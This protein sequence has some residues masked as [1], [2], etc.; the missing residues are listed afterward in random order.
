MPHFDSLDDCPPGLRKLI[1]AKLKEESGRQIA[2]PTRSGSSR[3]P[4]PTAERISA[5]EAEAKRPKYGNKPTERIAPGGGVIKFDSKKEAARYDWL[6]QELAAGRIT[7][8]K[9]Q[10]QILIQPSFTDPVTGE[11][12]RA[13]SYL[14]DFRYMRQ[15]DAGAWEE[16]IEDAKGGSGRK[17]TQT[18]TFRLKKKLLA[19]R[20]IRVV[21]V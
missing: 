6:M 12:T 3:T 8:L 15:N 10:Y 5:G 16:V 4:T 2:A 13:I 7:D 11:H 18:D 9:L 14:A 19:E 17:G 20:G 21:V 1:E